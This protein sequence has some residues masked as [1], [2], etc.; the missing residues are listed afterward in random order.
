MAL[1]H[2]VIICSPSAFG[3]CNDQNTTLESVTINGRTQLGNELEALRQPGKPCVFFNR[4][5]F[6]VGLAGS[7]VD[8]T[9]NARLGVAAVG[10]R[11]F[12]FFMCSSGRQ[13]NGPSVSGDNDDNGL[14]ILDATFTI[15]NSVE[16][17]CVAF[18][19]KKF[20][21]GAAAGSLEMVAST[22]ITSF[23]TKSTPRKR[24]VLSDKEKTRRIVKRIVNK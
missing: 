10:N 17:G 3:G 24:T 8:V 1:C 23:T 14:T 20:G 12:S 11:N 18:L 9:I 16:G 15:G 4:N 22:S 7:S 6:D 5:G 2:Y 21:G 19:E 13:Y